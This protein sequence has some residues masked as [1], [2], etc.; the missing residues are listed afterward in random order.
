MMSK[1]TGNTGPELT[2][3]TDR[4]SEPAVT[5]VT[6]EAAATPASVAS[7]ASTA[8]ATST[9]ATASATSVASSGPSASGVSTAPDRAQA[10]VTRRVAG[11]LLAGGVLVAVVSLVLMGVAD[12]DAT[13]RYRSSEMGTWALLLPPA[14]AVVV[15]TVGMTVRKSYGAQGAARAYVFVGLLLVLLYLRLVYGLFA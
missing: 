4:P 3:G 11:G 1:L 5:T 14:V 15:G 2:F 8:S 13:V 9:A 12:A 10:A 6:A 7:T